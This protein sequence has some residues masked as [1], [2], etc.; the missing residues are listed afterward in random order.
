MSSA[1]R[2]RFRPITSNPGDYCRITGPIGSRGPVLEV[3]IRLHQTELERYRLEGR[4]A[5]LPFSARAIIDTAAQR[6]CIRASAAANLRLTPVGRASVSSTSGSVQ[7][8][9]YSLSLQ[10]GLTLDRLPNPIEVF[11]HSVPAIRG[12]ELLIGLDVL[13]RCKLTLDGPQSRYELIL[14]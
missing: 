14:P 13:R 4:T 11:A 1:S 9:V 12:A 10:L 3:E 7:S 5:P 6:T 8:N 2:G